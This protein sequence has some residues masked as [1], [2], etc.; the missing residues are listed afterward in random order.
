MLGDTAGMTA[1]RNRAATAMTQIRPS[2]ARSGVYSVP[3][4]DDPPYTATSLLLAGQHAQAAR[5]TRRLIQTTYRPHARPPQD[6]PTN[7]ARTLLVLA[8]AAVGL[9]DLDEAAATGTAALACGPM[10]WPTL[11]LAGQLDQSL[12][13]RFPSEAHRRLPRTVHRRRQPPRAH[14]IPRHAR[15]G[16]R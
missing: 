2:A 7:Y 4:D 5:M 8:L 16:H 9:G 11:V 3:L 14:R 13:R 6:Q 15:Q 10:A 1:A 12:T